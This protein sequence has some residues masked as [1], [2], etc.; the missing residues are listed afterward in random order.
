[1]RTIL[2]GIK[3]PIE[4]ENDSIGAITKKINKKNV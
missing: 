2:T 3:M 1:M 4:K